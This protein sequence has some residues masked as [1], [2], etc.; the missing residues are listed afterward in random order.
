M[1]APASGTNSA[2]RASVVSL[3]TIAVGP[4]S[5]FQGVVHDS[6]SVPI[7]EDHVHPAVVVLADIDRETLLAQTEP[8]MD[9]T[10]TVQVHAYDLMEDGNEAALA[11]ALDALV[12]AI[13]QAL[14]GDDDWR[15]F[16]RSI[17]ASST[18]Q[19]I[20]STTRRARGKAVLS[21]DLSWEVQHDQTT[22][23]A[24]QF[25]EAHITSTEGT[26]AEVTN[27]YS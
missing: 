22:A 6:R 7:D 14:F 10:L 9:R 13:R 18:R 2:V 21:L 19:F 3:L 17:G 23:P 20:D 1:P 12:E 27:I 4:A 24:D 8:F 16:F 11:D 26:S 15:M 25:R 5:A